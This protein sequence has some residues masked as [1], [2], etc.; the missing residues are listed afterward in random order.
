MKTTLLKT[1][2]NHYY[3]LLVDD[4]TK[5]YFR[6]IPD[7]K[8]P[9]YVSCDDTDDDEFVVIDSSYGFDFKVNCARDER[10]GKAGDV[11]KVSNLVHVTSNGGSAY[12][13]VPDKK[14]IPI[15]GDLALESEYR[16]WVSG[17]SDNVVE[18]STTASKPT[19]STSKSN[20]T[21]P[22]KLS[23]LA[24]HLKNYPVPTVEKDGWHVDQGVWE[25]LLLNNLELR[26]NTL[27]VGPSGTGKTELLMLF[28]KKVGRE[29]K[30][31]DMA[32][33]LDSVAAFQGTH[34]VGPQGSYFD[35]AKF[36]ED[37][38]TNKLLVL[39]EIN[40]PPT[41]S[42]NTLFSVLDERRMLKLSTASHGMSDIVKV[43]EGCRFLATANE[44]ISYTG[45]GIMDQALRDRFPSVVELDYLP[46]DIEVNVLVKKTGISKNDAMRIAAIADK[47]RKIYKSD[48]GLSKGVSMRQTQMAAKYIVCGLSKEQAIMRT[49]LTAFTSEE[50]K[51]I[52]RSVIAQG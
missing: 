2:P 30:V 8:K 37:I 47:L 19:K 50:E 26:E 35:K 13:F 40:R 9:Q 21:P 43:H 34:R 27:M 17:K 16:N 31:I 6:V 22:S 10:V 28:A 42:T 38:T 52:A 41:S 36:A 15:K 25:Q 29:I 4:P 45:A 7:T 5:D 24:R 49:I 14:L 1:A 20:G 18:P 3:V 44:G 11:M 51:Q 46:L 48:D 23:P 39:D 12:L 33:M 32:G